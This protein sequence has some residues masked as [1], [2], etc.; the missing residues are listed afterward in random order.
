MTNLS[1]RKYYISSTSENH[2]PL[3]RLLISSI[4]STL[5]CLT[6]TCKNASAQSPANVK[7]LPGFGLNSPPVLSGVIFYG[8]RISLNGRIMPGIWLQRRQKTGSLTTHVSDATLRQ[9]I[10]VDLLNSRTPALQP[11]QWFSSSTKPLN[12]T[13]LVTTGYR[14]LDITNFAKT[15]QWRIY[16][17]DNT[18]MISTPRAKITNIRQGKQQNGERIVVDLNRPTPWQITQELVAKKSQPQIPLSDSDTE[19]SKPASPPHKE[20][21]ITLDAIA[22]PSLVNAQHAMLLSDTQHLTPQLEVV[23]NQTIIRLS[24]PVGLSPQISTLPNP[25]RL[26]IDIQPDAL[27]ERSIDWAPGLRWQQRYVN[28]GEERFP[29]V[30]L[31]VDPREYGIKLKPIWTNPDSLVGTAPLIETAQQNLAV[32]AINGGFFNRNNR[33]P[34]GAIRYNNQWLSSPILNRGAIAWNDSGEFSISR[35]I[36]RETLIG[37]NKVQLPILTLNSGY[38][39]TGIARYTPAWGATYTSLTDNEIILSIENNK[40]VTQHTGRKAGE[41]TVAIP[42]NGYLLT[43]RGNST[44]ISRL[45]VGSTVRIVSSTSP[46]NFNRYPYIMGAGPMLLQNRQIVLDAKSEQFSDAFVKQK[47]IRSAICTTTTGKLMIA[48][49]HN[50]VGGEGPSLAEHAQLMQFMGCVNALNLDGGSSTSLYLGGQLLNRS[51]HTAARVHN[52]IGIFLEP[53]QPSALK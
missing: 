53:S 3:L 52:G 32:A 47:A 35:L 4:L 20:W 25:N 48:A 41:T 36:L 44:D 39:Q 6:A 2:Q 8:N 22:N 31:E 1:R 46:T 43:F 26:V 30:W 5:V 51:P 27:V 38:V 45:P 7:T 34:L 17:N 9:L 24:V 13:S 10:G 19:I 28:L 18:L 29:V 15:A 21:T 37:T 42:P 14:Y 11:V 12:L 49:V 16:V 33:L 50:R 40:I 23:N